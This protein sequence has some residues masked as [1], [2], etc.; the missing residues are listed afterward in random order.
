MN[1]KKLTL[2][3]SEGGLRGLREFMEPAVPASEEKIEDGAKDTKWD[4]GLF[5]KWLD[6]RTK[7]MKNKKERDWRAEINVCEEIILLDRQA[8]FISIMI[9]LF[10]KDMA[11]AYEKLEDSDNT[12]RYYRLAKEGLLKYR[13]EHKLN[14]TD[15]WLD[16][17]NSIDE[18]ILK[19]TGG[20]AEGEIV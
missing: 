8:K 10:Y 15:D 12:L 18:R 17:I 7:F 16:E 4:D 9:P 14:D 5:Q 13:D 11:K 1:K 6:L 19:L 3:K 20:G 2:D